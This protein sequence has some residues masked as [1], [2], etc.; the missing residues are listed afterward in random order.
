M[1]SLI[2][3]QNVSNV[4]FSIHIIRQTCGG[5]IWDICCFR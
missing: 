5:N 3:F 2:L 4:V 1:Q